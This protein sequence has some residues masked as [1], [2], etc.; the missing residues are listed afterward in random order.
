MNTNVTSLRIYQAALIAA[1]ALTCAIAGA[2]VTN[3][4][5]S[6]EFKPV[7]SVFTLP[8]SAKE[9]RDPFFPRS[10]RPYESAQPVSRPGATNVAPVIELAVGGVSGSAERPLVIINNVTFG[11][12]DESDVMIK[13]RRIRVRCL[14]IN[15]PESR[16]RVQVGN[17]LCDLRLPARN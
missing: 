4:P 12:N 8:A 14:E 6:G 16:V 2:A 5:A 15:L 13:G 9:G 1:L 11:V 3:N 17:D 7:A 10:L